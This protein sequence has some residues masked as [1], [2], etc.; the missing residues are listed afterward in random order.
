[1]SQ[2]SHDSVD[3]TLG[4]EHQDELRNTLAGL[5]PRA[6]DPDEDEAYTPGPLMSA[7]YFK[8]PTRTTQTLFACSP[9]IEQTQKLYSID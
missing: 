3:E 9:N 2:S 8:R 4:E 5:A 7:N 6:R 1:M